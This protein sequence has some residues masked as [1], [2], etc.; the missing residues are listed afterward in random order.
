MSLPGCFCGCHGKELFY[1][2][3][4]QE[5]ARPVPKDALEATV[6]G[7]VPVHGRLMCTTPAQGRRA[8]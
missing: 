8:R 4:D 6:G 3:S 1:K 2:C 5:V 7:E